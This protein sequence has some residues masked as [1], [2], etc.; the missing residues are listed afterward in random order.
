MSWRTVVISSNAKLDYQ[1]GYLVVRRD[2]IKKVYIDTQSKI[3]NSYFSNQ[4]KKI[5][6]TEQLKD[7]NSK[8]VEY[9]QYVG[10]DEGQVLYS[11]FFQKM[12]DK[13]K[14]KEQSYINK[15]LIVVKENKFTKVYNKI[16]NYFKNLVFQ[17]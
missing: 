16:K 13:I 9:R 7:F 10:S 2:D 4:F 6:N 12:Q 11:E 1:M 5:K 14:E 17:N 8:L 15:A 3:M